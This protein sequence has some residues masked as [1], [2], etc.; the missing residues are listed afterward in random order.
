MIGHIDKKDLI[1]LKENRI[2]NIKKISIL[3]HIENCDTCS[4]EL[5][6]IY[7]EKDLLKTPVGF[8]QGIFHKIDSAKVKKS[9]KEKNL[10]FWG[11]TFRVGLA[12]CAS[13][14]IVFANP[15]N[16]FNGLKNSNIPTF[17][18]AYVDNITSNIRSFSNKIII[19]GSNK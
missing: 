13:L 11:Y 4:L 6:N 16:V 7:K 3:E 17:N 15:L 10:E 18:L 14:I 2:N 8:E 9:Q 5:S 19:W 12:M 1:L